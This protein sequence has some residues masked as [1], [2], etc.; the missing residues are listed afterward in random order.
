V[1]RAEPQG[2]AA[3]LRA[4]TQDL[5][6]A[7]ERSGAMAALLAGELE[8]PGY[9]IMLRNLQAIYG[10]MEAGLERHAA[11]FD[12]PLP[13]LSRRASLALDLAALGAPPDTAL[14]PATAC[15]VQHL[16]YIG[17][18]AAQDARLLLAHAYVRYLGDLHGG[19]LLKQCIKRSLDLDGTIGTRFYDFGPPA[20]VAWLIQAVRT[21]LD[22]ASRD[23]VQVDALVAEARLA[24]QLHVELFQ[25]LP[26]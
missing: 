1:G 22:A 26:H 7:A 17:A 25:Q 11:L 9:V 10:A 16:R 21:G 20:Q 2:L 15:Y 8:R 5:H 24:F 3:R 12:L 6:R 18:P 19:Q 4:G 13:L 23:T 14:A